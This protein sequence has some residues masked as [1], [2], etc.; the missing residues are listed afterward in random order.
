MSGFPRDLAEAGPWE[1]SL[2]RSLARRSHSARGTVSATTVFS[3]GWAF[4]PSDSIRNL[5]DSEPWDLSSLRSRT[6][7]RAADLQFVPSSA[8]A[9]RFSIGTLVALAAGPAVALA[10]AGS[11]SAHHRERT[12][13]PPPEPPTTSEHHITLQ[14]GSEGRQVRI[15]QH[16]LGIAVDGIYGPRTEAT[17][18]AFQEREGLPVDGVVGATTSAALA[19]HSPAVAAP[20]AMLSPTAGADAGETEVGADG[21]RSSGARDSGRAPATAKLAR[22]E[23]AET[24]G[25]AAGSGAQTTTAQHPDSEGRID[26][27]SA[28]DVS[29]VVRL[30][31]KLGVSVDGT[32]GPETEAAVRKL[33]AADRLHVD[34]VV[35]PA[36][37]G[38]LKLRQNVVLHPEHP[39]GS[40]L[41]DG[42]A[43]DASGPQGHSDPVAPQAVRR[44]AAVSGAEAVR[45][46][47]E[48]LHVEADGRQR[49]P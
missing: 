29:P 27:E 46:L 15:L 45:R 19:G 6:R 22:V 42:Q 13:P 47:Q 10:D 40:R 8:R 9:R 23:V 24:G 35:G 31:E 37:W 49:R 26:H 44:P 16:R 33:Q 32:F 38:A 21:D 36:T 25:T 5:A 11:G 1:E 14:S 3:R 48:A 30:Q 17:V 7:R 20:A 43:S 4:P 12:S 18:R 39:H 2:A 34:G 28:R 41:A